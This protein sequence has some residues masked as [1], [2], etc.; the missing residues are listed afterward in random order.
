MNKTFIG[1]MTQVRDIL[2]LIVFFSACCDYQE[3]NESPCLTGC[4]HAFLLPGTVLTL[5]LFIRPSFPLE[6]N[7]RHASN[8]SIQTPL[9]HTLENT[10]TSSKYMILFHPRLTHLRPF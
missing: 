2:R 9:L 6:C 7:D 5:A 8:Q 4:A 3:P 1:W 10:L